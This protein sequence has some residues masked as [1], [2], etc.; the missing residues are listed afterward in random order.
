MMTPSCR[1][2]PAEVARIAE[3]VEL[4]RLQGAKL[5]E[6]IEVRSEGHAEHRQMLSCSAEVRFILE[7]NR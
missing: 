7:K 3:I 6:L 2:S 4:N 5:L 1:M